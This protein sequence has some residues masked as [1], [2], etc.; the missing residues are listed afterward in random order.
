MV[1]MAMP[2]RGAVVVD[3]RSDLAGHVVVVH[4]L[5]VAAVPGWAC[6]SYQDSLLTEPMQK[7][8]TRPASM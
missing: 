7:N 2:G 5:D 4:G 8:F 1:V 3:E 6:L